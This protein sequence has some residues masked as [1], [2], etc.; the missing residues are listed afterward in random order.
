M[1]KNTIVNP[2]ADVMAATT[3]SPIEIP[4]NHSGA[5]AVMPVWGGVVTF[6]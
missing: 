5:L 2:Y 1:P 3:V 6:A 4:S